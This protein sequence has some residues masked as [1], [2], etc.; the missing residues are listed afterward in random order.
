MLRVWLGGDDIDMSVTYPPV[1][2]ITRSWRRLSQ[3][4]DEVGDA[5]VWGGIHFRSADRDGI[6]VGRRIGAIVVREFPNS[7]R[8]RRIGR[9]AMITR[10]LRRI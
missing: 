5:R 10:R 4:T 9:A 8:R 6:D 7:P 1:L 3:I 2:G